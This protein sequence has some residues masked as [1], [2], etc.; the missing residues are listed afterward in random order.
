MSKETIMWDTCVIIDA[1]T[2]SHERYHHIAP[3]VHRAEA[4]DL[5]IVISMASV[6]EIFFLRELRAQGVSQ[7]EQNEMIRRWFD[8]SYIVKRNV[9]L[10]V[11]LKAGELRRQHQSLTTVDSIIL[12]TATLFDVTALVTIDGARA[13]GAGGLTQ[14]DGR[15]GDNAPRIVTPE[16]YATPGSLNL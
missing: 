7:E 15:L 2:Q 8:N 14:L 6:A 10:F 1:I 13:K 16:N 12:A 5:Q 9:D 11:G 3:M 4:N